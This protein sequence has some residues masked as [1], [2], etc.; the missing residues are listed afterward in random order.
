MS[1]TSPRVCQPSPDADQKI[2]LSPIQTQCF[3]LIAYVLLLLLDISFLRGKY[4]IATERIKL[5]E[6]IQRQ[7]THKILSPVGRPNG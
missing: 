7:E 3:Y 6:R 5:L 4:S 1:A 2:L